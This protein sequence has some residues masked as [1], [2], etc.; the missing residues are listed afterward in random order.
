ML[1]Q[2]KLNLLDSLQKY[3]VEKEF[4]NNY[5]NKMV[6]RG[7]FHCPGDYDYLVVVLMRCD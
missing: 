6:N 3:L 4:G 5:K 7:L 2:K 1:F